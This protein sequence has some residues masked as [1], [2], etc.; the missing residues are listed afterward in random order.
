MDIESFVTALIRHRKAGGNLAEILD[1]LSYV[2]RCRE[3]QKE[4][5]WPKKLAHIAVFACRANPRVLAKNPTFPRISSW[6]PAIAQV[7][8][9]SAPRSDP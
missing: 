6:A 9:S 7:F 8:Q 1:N 4:D 2:I 5:L 3:Y